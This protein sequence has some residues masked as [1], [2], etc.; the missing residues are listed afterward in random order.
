VTGASVTDLVDQYAL[1]DYKVQS[2]YVFDGKPPFTD[3]TMKDQV[4]QS[5]II[6]ATRAPP[7]VTRLLQPISLPLAQRHPFLPRFPSPNTLGGTF[8]LC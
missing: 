8:L 1:A 7:E 4:A 3:E 6:Y 2:S 5:P